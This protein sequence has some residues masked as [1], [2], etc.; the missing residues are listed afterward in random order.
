MHPRTE[1]I[2]MLETSLAVDVGADA[3]E[4]VATVE[5]AGDDPAE[6]RFS[7]GQRVSVVVRDGDRTVWR[8]DEGQM[9]AQMLGSDEVPPGGS[10]QYE[11]TLSNPSPGDYAAEATVVA[12]DRDL[13]A[14]A[15]F[16]V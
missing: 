8:S 9:F 3:V 2:D 7:D 12:R 13:T 5:N 15:T 14:E 1:R 16:S 4:F 11:A 6:L 10:V